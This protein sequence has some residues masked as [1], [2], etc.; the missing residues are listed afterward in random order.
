MSVTL[1]IYYLL[2]LGA[3]LG[4]MV[5]HPALGVFAYLATYTINPSGQWWG[6]N[7]PEFASRYS[8]ILGLCIPISAVLHAG[9]LRFGRLLESQEVLLIIFTAIIAMS[10]ILSPGG[11][12]TTYIEK[13]V[14]VC[15]VLLLATHI[16]TTRKLYEGILWVLIL[17]GFYIAWELFSGL[18]EFWGGRLQG[19]VGGSDFSE[20]NFMAAHFGAVLPL[21]GGMFLAGS[22]WVRGVLMIFGAFMANAIVM[23]RSRGSF[24]GLAAGAIAALFFSVGLKRYRRMLVG[25]MIVGLVGGYSL[26]DAGFWER[27]NTM[28]VDSSEMDSS[29]ESRLEFWKG[30]LLMARDHP[31]GLGAGRFFDYT[32]AYT[33][34]VRRDT[35]NTLLR[36]LAELGFPGFTVLVLLIGNSFVALR[37]VSRDAA[38][39]DAESWQIYVLHCTCLRLAI[40][41][42]LVAAMFISSTYIEETY[43]F[44]LMPVML[45]RAVNTELEDREALVEAGVLPET[46][47][48]PGEE[49]EPEGDGTRWRDRGRMS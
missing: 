8:F 44:L 31:L 39:L 46:G 1:I 18:G 4:S 47:D 34:H 14:K 24:L 32:E 2:F 3:V 43:W 6:Q 45:Q 13:M 12:D 21:T 28:S 16:I 7:M 5:V 15:F 48:A 9:K 26:T 23:V 10:H 30:A 38:G 49:D 25:L 29:A 35:H 11:A 22:T 20:G 33:G 37:R 36:C 17:S 27:M 40:I 41:S 42:Y 19:G